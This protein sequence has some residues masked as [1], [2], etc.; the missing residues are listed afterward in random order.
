MLGIYGISFL[1][2][3][4]H[5]DFAASLQH[6][7]AIAQGSQ[8]LVNVYATW[9]GLS[10]VKWTNSYSYTNISVWASRISFANDAIHASLELD[11]RGQFNSNWI[12]ALSYI[13][14]S[15][16][17][18]GMA[19]DGLLNNVERARILCC[20]DLKGLQCFVNYEKLLV[21]DTSAVVMGLNLCLDESTLL[22]CEFSR[23]PTARGFYNAFTA[24]FI[25]NVRK[26]QVKM[27]LDSHGTVKSAIA[28]NILPNLA[29]TV[30]AS[31]ALQTLSCSAGLA[32][33][34]T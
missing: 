16:L 8:K 20:L 17:K 7:K 29:V 11:K 34:M 32:M 14:H 33:A 28:S 9:S 22:S 1:A 31:L 3:T 25:M 24:G 10:N 23:A 30:N 27:T 2:N 15:S 21:K 19:G 6:V 4:S 13:P 26:T 5:W 18:V 12:A